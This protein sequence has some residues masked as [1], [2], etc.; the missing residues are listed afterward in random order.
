MFALWCPFTKYLVFAYAT[1]IPDA[2]MTVDSM[3]GF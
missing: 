1:S 3:H 2:V